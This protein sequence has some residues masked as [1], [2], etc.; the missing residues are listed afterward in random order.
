[1]LDRIPKHAAIASPSE[2]SSSFDLAASSTTA[3]AAFSTIRNLRSW[4]APPSVRPNCLALRFGSIWPGFYAQLGPR[5]RTPIGPPQALE[6][7][8][9]SRASLSVRSGAVVIFN[10]GVALD[11]ACIPRCPTAFRNLLRRPARSAGR[12]RQH[13]VV[14][15]RAFIPTIRNDPSPALL[16]DCILRTSPCSSWG[17]RR[18]QLDRS[19]PRGRQLPPR[20]QHGASSRTSGSPSLVGP[21]ATR[22]L[23]NLIGQ[24][25]QARRSP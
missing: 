10:P 5:P 19:G 24:I 13:C 23:P 16:H 15:G 14:R 2:W 1:M 12:R 21:G 3:F 11:F 17:T 7:S 20:H 6:R 9:H 8:L 18:L 25:S 22:P 4:K